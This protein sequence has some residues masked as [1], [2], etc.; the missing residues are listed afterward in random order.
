MNITN[1]MTHANAIL[2]NSTVDFQ[3]FKPN[4]EINS[5]STIQLNKDL[6][7]VCMSEKHS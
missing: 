4:E 6:K 7:A 3:T 5:T 1:K 2:L